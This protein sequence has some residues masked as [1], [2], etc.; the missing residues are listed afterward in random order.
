MRDHREHDA[1]EAAREA[2]VSDVQLE[3]YHLGELPPAAKAALERR[4]AGDAALRARLDALRL[5]DEA[6]ARA[7]DV[8]VLAHSARER[9]RTHIL[10]ERAQ[11]AAG[12]R[13][14]G[15]AG[16]GMPRGLARAAGGLALLALVAVPSWRVLTGEHSALVTHEA[17]TGLPV[18]AAPGMPV[19][20]TDGAQPP[21]TPVAGPV[22]PGRPLQPASPAATTQRDPA[23]SLPSPDRM[24]AAGEDDIRLK[25]FEAALALFRRTSSG[26][27]PL[28]PGATV[29][30]GDVVRIGYR[31]G[32]VA[33]GAI[34]SV[35]GNGNVT[36]HW[37]LTGDSAARL[38][39]GEALLPGAF[40]LDDAPDFERFYLLT[41]DRSFD[42][43]PLL[44]SLHAAKAPAARGLTVVRFDLLKEN[45]I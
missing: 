9:H 36:R 12:R 14:T 10:R 37:P 34:F 4:L 44:A 18:E 29:K 42:L 32:G 20:G 40:E 11:A 16:F 26:A 3:R 8:G 13:D 38:E 35:D 1:S 28:K 15:V 27:E 2:R 41:S 33:F 17:P 5:D 25:G 6:F 39:R 45:G 43:K 30:P 19:R 21:E 31:T 22:S 24:A 23:P 7:R